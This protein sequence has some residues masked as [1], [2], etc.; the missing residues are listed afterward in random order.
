MVSY[1]RYYVLFSKSFLGVVSLMR[2][3]SIKRGLH[4]IYWKLTA[5]TG[6]AHV[7]GQKN[8]A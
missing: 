4:K 3:I 1:V 2:Y 7:G 5:M 6:G 8:I